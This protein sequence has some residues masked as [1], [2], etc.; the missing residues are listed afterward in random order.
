MLR[1]GK[2]GASV[3]KAEANMVKDKGETSRGTKTD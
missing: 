2:L 1:Q 3:F